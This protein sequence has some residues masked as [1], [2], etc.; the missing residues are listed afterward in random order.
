MS[1]SNSYDNMGKEYD[2]HRI[3]K[4]LKLDVQAYKDYSPIFLSTTFALQYGLSFAATMALV[5]HTGLY[6]GSDLWRRL[7]HRKNEPKD[8]HGKLIERYPETPLWWFM[9]LM[10]IIIAI[11]FVTVLHWD[12][13][14]PWWGYI[15]ALTIAG[16]FLVWFLM[17]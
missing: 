13:Q 17:I 6:H 1:D 7:F 4:D 9:V 5:I 15:L 3:L 10:A 12:T 14:L 8:I 11:G 16:F 2:V